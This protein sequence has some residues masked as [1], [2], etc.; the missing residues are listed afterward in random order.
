MLSQLSPEAAGKIGKAFNGKSDLCTAFLTLV[1]VQYLDSFDSHPPLSKDDKWVNDYAST[2]IPTPL[3]PIPA[4]TTTQSKKS[5]EA[6]VKRSCKGA[7]PSGP[8]T[9]RHKLQL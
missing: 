6:V 2:K 1:I 9:C 4:T 5:T 8:T 7:E 3:Q